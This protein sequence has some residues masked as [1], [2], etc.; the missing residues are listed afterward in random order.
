MDRPVIELVARA[1][2]H[3]LAF[4][5]NRNSPREIA[6]SRQIMRNEQ[7]AKTVLRL[8]IQDEIEDLSL[9]RDVKGADRFV[10]YDEARLGDEGARNCD[11][12]SLAPRKLTR[13]ALRESAIKADALQHRLDAASA[14]G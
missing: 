14:L 2:F 4:A 10:E 5:H 8:Q 1:D 9:H 11:S 3:D 6:G 12:L 13:K 7:R